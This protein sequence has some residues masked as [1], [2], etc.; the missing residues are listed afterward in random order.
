MAQAF[1]SGDYAGF[2]TVSSVMLIEGLT[3]DE[4]VE[5]SKGLS[6]ISIQPGGGIINDMVH[7]DNE[8]Q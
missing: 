2:G 3:Y 1:D 4:M 6:P 7:T 8:E 5:L